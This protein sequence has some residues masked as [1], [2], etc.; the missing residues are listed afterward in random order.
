MDEG[1]SKGLA[2]FLPRPEI[3]F[4]LDDLRA[5][6]FLIFIKIKAKNFFLGRLV[7]TH[8]P[9]RAHGTTNFE[10]KVIKFRVFLKRTWFF[11]CLHPYPSP[12]TTRWAQQ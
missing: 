10:T 5:E 1:T 11:S 2:G 8:S 6:T 7:I 3:K 12:A 9:G 4:F